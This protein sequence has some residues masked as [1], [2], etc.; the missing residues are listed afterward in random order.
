MRFFRKSKSKKPDSPT[1][2]GVG[3][4][5]AAAYSGRAD[6]DIH[7]YLAT[8]DLADKVIVE[9][10]G[11]IVALQAA[12]PRLLQGLITIVESRLG[13]GKD[14]GKDLGRIRFVSPME[15]SQLDEA[16][17]AR[18][19]EKKSGSKQSEDAR[20]GHHAMEWVL[21]QA[22]DA[23]A[24]D[25][26]LDI[27]RDHAQLSFRIYGQV[28]RI[29]Q[30]A[31]DMGIR[32]ARGLFT[33]G[34]AK[35]QELAA[36]DASFSHQHDDRLYRVRCNS[37][38]DTRGQSVSCRV[39]DPEFVLPL[40]QSGYSEHQIDLIQ[41]ICRASG[42][43]ILITGETNS[44]KSTTLA[45][46]MLNS[47]RGERMIEIADPV[48]IEFEHCTHV[49]IDR[50][51]E[52]PEGEFRSV[53]AATVRQDPDALVLGEIRDEPTAIAAQ[54]MAIQG[55]RVYSTLHTQ[56]CVAAIPRLQNLGVDHHLLTL[57][58]F[59][60]GIVN[61]SLVPLVC[62]ECGLESHPDPALDR[63]YRRLF[64]DAAVLRYIN[65]PGCNRCVSGV[66][67]QTLVAEVYP[68]YLDRQQAHQIIARNEL[69]KLK[70]YMQQTYGVQ[71]KQEH[72]ADKVRL[73]L[74][75]PDRTEAIVGD[76]SQ[77]SS[78][79]PAMPIP[80]WQ[81]AETDGTAGTVGE[82]Q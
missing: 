75:D 48:E 19:K 44:G 54:S 27:R 4:A 66:V 6:R 74:I 15:F 49:E 3:S 55:K 61:Q 59:L 9:D 2:D 81:V 10:D 36:C 14:P 42:G 67:G 57:P 64:G 16:R 69:W 65:P 77:S 56:S 53:L 34:D 79:P 22:I 51:G 43:L 30:M 76:L 70:G 11:S 82:L 7:A 52:D 32:V 72:A 31:R 58:E 8:A 60:A 78:S 13:D 26:Y 29:E 17:K 35:W 45:G 23:S 80:S 5:T 68:L 40:D 18:Q 41:R 39:R 47:P 1:R 62:P 12:D 37:L 20:A 38:P 24:S 50:Y 63:H 25:I 21:D 33:A 71:S 28:T 73:G 46:L